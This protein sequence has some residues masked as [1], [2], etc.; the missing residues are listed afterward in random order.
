MSKSKQKIPTLISEKCLYANLYVAYQSREGNLD[1][2]F[3]HENHAFPVPISEYD[4]L[5]KATSK[6]DFLHCMRSLVNVT[7]NAPDVSMKV[8]DGAAFV[9]MNRP[10]SSTTY[11]KYYED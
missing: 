4:K 5:R 10:K 8:I 9:N 1:N 11:E 7:Y 6:F 3:A 2:F